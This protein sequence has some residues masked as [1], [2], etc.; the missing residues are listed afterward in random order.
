MIHLLTQLIHQHSAWL[1]TPLAPLSFMKISTPASGRELGKGKILIMVFEE[2]EVWPTLCVKTT[3]MYSTGE[4]IKRNQNNLKLLEEGVLG[5][6]YAQ[7][8]A[9]SLYLYDDGSVIFCIESVCP[10]IRFSARP[11]NVELVM[12]KYIAWQSYLAQNTTKFQTFE[13]DIRLPMIVQHGDMTPDNV[14][15]SGENIYL[16]DYDNVGE[17]QLAG[18]DIFNFLS[19]LRRSPEVINFYY[20]EYFPRYF[21]SIGAQVESY[22]DILPFYRKEE[23]NRKVKIS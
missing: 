3:R 15:V 23:S 14:L 6:L 18:F 9:K 17:N 8:F 21:K 7:M 5:S 20:E 1:K 10:G 4:I 11:Y 19:K 13:N 16:I 2:G 12:K 22:E